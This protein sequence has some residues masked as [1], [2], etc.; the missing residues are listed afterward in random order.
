MLDFNPDIMVKTADYPDGIDVISSGYFSSLGE[1][2]PSI[3][4]D[5]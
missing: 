5:P 4:K 1:L 3:N 2:A